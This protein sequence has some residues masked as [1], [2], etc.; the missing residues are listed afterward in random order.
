MKHLKIMLTLL[1]SILAVGASAQ[2]TRT[3]WTTTANDLGEGLYEIN[4]TASIPEDLHIYALGNLGGYNPTTI[5]IQPTKKVEIIGEV[6][7]SVE[8]HIYYDEV[9]KMEMGDYS[10]EVTFTQQVRTHKAGKELKVLI[11]WQECTDQTCQMGEVEQSVVLDGSVA[12][13][14][15]KE[16]ATVV[17][18]EEAELSL[19]ILKENGIDAYMIGE[20][21]EGE[22]KV[23]L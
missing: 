1:M 4:V 8:P 7:P 15:K 23:I 5:T 2:A 13:K 17:P 9:F 14:A 18:A 16:K 10:G 6:T 19:S 3:K 22:E 21:I 11:E 12:G 20:I